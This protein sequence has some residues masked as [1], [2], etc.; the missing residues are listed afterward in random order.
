MTLEILDLLQEV[1]K[2]GKGKKL[3][4]KRLKMIAVI[5][6]MR[7]AMNRL[8]IHKVFIV[9]PAICPLP[10]ASSHLSHQG[11]IIPSYR[12]YLL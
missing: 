4:Q 11:L 1:E 8:S 3:M 5:S 9:P 12:Y 7:N 10:P 6:A 2:E